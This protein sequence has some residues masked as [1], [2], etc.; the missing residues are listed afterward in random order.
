MSRFLIAILG[1]ACILPAAPPTRPL[2]LAEAL[3][4]AVA[5]ATAENSRSEVAASQLRVLEA[6]N[7]WKVELRPSLGIFSFSN[8]ALFA[9]TLGSSLLMGSGTLL[10]G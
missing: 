6:A 10:R 3:Q 4:A 1:A 9:A 2:S 7:K 5:R 8:P